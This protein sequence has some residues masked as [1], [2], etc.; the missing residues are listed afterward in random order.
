MIF[1]MT[2]SQSIKRHLIILLSS[3]G[4]ATSATAIQP[5]DTTLAP[6]LEPPSLVFKEGEGDYPFFR[7]PTI[8]QSQKGTLLAFA[9][10]R[11]IRDDH[12]RNDI[13][14]KRSSDG[15]KTWGPLQVIQADKELVMVNPS[16]VALSSG[17]L[18]VFYETFPH[19][20]HARHGRH[21]KM[22]DGGFGMHTQKLLVRAS[23]DDGKTWSKPVELQKTS[24]KDK[25]IISSGS[26]ANAIQLQ[27][28][29]HKGR[30][31]LPL[32]L[33][34][35]IDAKK[36]TWKNAVLYSDDEA[37]SWKRSAYIPIEKT[38]AGNECLIAE[39]NDG[40]VLMNARSQKSKHRLISRSQDG[41]TTWSPFTYSQ[42]LKNRPCNCG[43]LK[44]SYAN[45]NRMFFSYNNSLS[46]R[47]NGF[48]AMSKDDGKSWPVKKQVVP[49]LFGY[50]QLVKV[51]KQT[52]GMIYEPFQSVKEEW[53]LYF[54]RI[55]LQW[56]EQ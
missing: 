12:G 24:R 10:G 31:L 48:V 13:V 39:T 38:E 15:G 49:G 51:D 7:I 50:S 19:G 36:R 32:F 33:T 17:R 44:F 3:L 4:L 26:P 53:S 14:L 23:D 47:A 20:Y 18:L 42:E 43:L 35:R 34:Q 30:I 27:T 5:S 2:H 8:C 41:G 52:L 46:K 55:P 22:M 56:I 9:E 11:Y 40:E 21:H 25:D 6:G 37:R 1:A 28:G 29:Q 16:P 54:V 45:D